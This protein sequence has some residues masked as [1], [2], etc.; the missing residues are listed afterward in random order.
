MGIL[1]SSIIGTI[2]AI[3]LIYALLSILVSI[4]IEFINHHT[5]TR[6]K[7]LKGSIKKM[8]D[9]QEASNYVDQFYSNHMVAGTSGETEEKNIDHI[10]DDLFSEVLIDIIMKGQLDKNSTGD[11]D[12]RM[13]LIKNAIE[14]IEDNK[15]LK[16]LLLSFCFKSGNKYEEFVKYIKEWY[17]EFMGRVSILYKEKQRPKLFLIGLVVALTLNVDSIFL[18]N[19][20]NKNDTLRNELNQVADNVGEGYSDLDEEQKQNTNDL[21]DL[22]KNGLKSVKDSLSS[23]TILIDT[24]KYGKYLKKTEVLIQLLDSVEK[25]KLDQTKEA[26]AL[27]SDLSIPIGWDCDHAP[28]SWF[29]SSEGEKK[30]SE[31]QETKKEE[32]NI[33]EV[34]VDNQ[35]ALREYVN[36]RNKGGFNNVFLYIVGILISAFSLS[37]G[38]PF[39]FQVLSKF[40]NLKNL[41][42]GKTNNK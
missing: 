8:L 3:T 11:D 30:D 41:A 39:W 10:S 22:T 5:N 1:N 34:K 9:G 32:E 27:V 24:V 33:T 40:I 7:H 13:E 42:K 16:D 36:S 28:L 29:S 15:P 4:L 37:F 19:V 17:N 26:L 23:P 35:T 2:I 21:L 38:A 6:S 18:F 20:I 25:E 14:A 12:N 31:K